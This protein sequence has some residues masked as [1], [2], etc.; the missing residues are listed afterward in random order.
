VLGIGYSWNRRR[1]SQL[2]W[3]ALAVTALATAAILGYSAFFYH[4]SEFV[5]PWLALALGGA[6]AC[7]PDR[8]SIRRTAVAVTAAAV[9]GAAAIQVHALAPLSTPGGAQLG[10]MIPPHACVVTD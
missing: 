5:A 9:L 3:C 1:P 7:L 2:E 4:Y 10:R 8:A 6:S